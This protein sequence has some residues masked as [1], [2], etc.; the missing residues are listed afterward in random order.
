MAVDSHGPHAKSLKQRKADLLIADKYL[1]KQYRELVEVSKLLSEDDFWLSHADALANDKSDFAALKKGRLNALQLNKTQK[2][3]L[4][5]NLTEQER[6][7]ILENDPTAR[8]AY[9]ELVPITKTEKEFWTLYL[10]KS[11]FS[12][13][14]AQAEELFSRYEQKKTPS[15][16]ASSIIK[17]LEPA[18]AEFNLLSSHGDYHNEEAL[19]HE[20]QRHFVQKDTI[21]KL[22]RESQLVMSALHRPG[23]RSGTNL[24]STELRDLRDAPAPNYVKLQLRKEVKPSVGGGS[25]SEEEGQQ[26]QQQQKSAFGKSSA[27]TMKGAKR[28]PPPTVQSPTELLSSLSI[29]FPDAERSR[30]TFIADRA[31][32]K[33]TAELAKM[34]TTTFA[35]FDMSED[36][37]VHDEDLMPPDTKQLCFEKFVEVTGLMRCFYLNLQNQGEA[38]PRPGTAA[39][40]KV[41][42]MVEKISAIKNEMLDKSRMLK[43]GKIVTGKALDASITAINELVKLSTRAVQWWEHYS[44]SPQTAA[45]STAQ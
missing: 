20:D 2:G 12:A 38:A 29:M 32:L 43:E 3:N 11:Y 8:R 31:N 6:Q 35:A 27:M 30:K 10:Q 14:S 15:A 22:N 16:N 39:A 18:D 13:E 17:K 25:G 1:G 28:R 24:A 40:A 36:A 9:E 41:A 19:A 26:Q 5:I 33:S 34:N 21:S 23:G 37:L 4:K 44:S 42:K 7:N 45:A